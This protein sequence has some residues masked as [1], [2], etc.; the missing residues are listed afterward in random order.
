MNAPLEYWKFLAGFG[1]FHFGMTQLEVGIKE[2]AGKRFK[3]FLKKYTTNRFLA[4]INGALTTVLFQSSSI[5]LLIVIA[6]AGA[7]IISLSNSLGIILGANLGTT[8]TGWLVSYFGFKVNINSFI[9]PIIG[10]GSLGSIF[11]SQRFKFYHIFRVS[12]AI[13]L[14][15]MGLE[16]MREGMSGLANLIDIQKIEKLGLWAFF[17]F[18]LIVTAVIQSSS[19]MMIITLGALHSNIITIIP[20]AFIVVGADLGTTMTALL[21]SLQGTS[22]K[23]RVGLAHLFFNLCTAILAIFAAKPILRILE[24]NTGITDPLYVLVGFH[25]SFNVLGILLFFPFLGL[26]EKFLNRL[27][28]RDYSKSCLFIHKVSTEVPEASLEAIRLELNHFIQIVFN[29]NSRLI[30]FEMK[31]KEEKKHDSIL[32]LTG[33]RKE[34]ETIKIYEKI[35][36]TEI[37]LLEYFVDLQHQKLEKNES[38]ALHQYIIVLRNGVQSAKSAKDIQHNLKEFQ[39]SVAQEIEDMMK[40]IRLNYSPIQMRIYDFPQRS[41]EFTPQTEL[42]EIALKNDLAYKRI[43]EWIYNT[44]QKRNVNSEHIATFLNVNREIFNSNTSLIEAIKGIEASQDI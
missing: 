23:K 22:V 32:F 38:K 10:L 12:I 18:G 34:E 42:T 37:E 19:A 25:S 39:D 20:A 8:I 13:G 2:I 29:F 28:L 40:E 17:A 5:I 30:G 11:I 3:L 15:L 4:V 1:L 43:N 35:K 27:F 7:G 24:T 6:F 9:F 33:L 21:A 44:L 31:I 16:F 36:K 41:R 26:F 14:L